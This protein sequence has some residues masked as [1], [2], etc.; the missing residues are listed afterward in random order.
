VDDQV[1]ERAPDV[2]G[3]AITAHEAPASFILGALVAY[4]TSVSF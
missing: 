2:D 3:D 4:E 1:G